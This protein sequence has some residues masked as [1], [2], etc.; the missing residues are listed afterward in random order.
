MKH[1]L[2]AMAVVALGGTA[3][4]R[5]GGSDVALSGDAQI[6]G[7]DGAV[8]ATTSPA[9]LDTVVASGDASLKAPLWTARLSRGTRGVLRTEFLQGQFFRLFELL[10]GSVKLD[11]AWALRA[12]T[13]VVRAQ[14]ASVE[15]SY[16]NGILVIKVGDG[17]TV[18]ITGTSA[19]ITLKNG[20]RLQISYDPATGTFTIVVDEDN[21]Q[22]IDVKIGKTTFQVSKGDDVTAKVSGDN[23]IVNAISGDV[24]L[25]G[26]DGNLVSVPQGGQTT[27][28]GGG[29]GAVTPGIQVPFTPGQ[30][31]NPKLLQLNPYQNPKTVMSN[32]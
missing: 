8:R 5:P 28:V 9:D 16:K 11:G 27:V 14:A 4:G 7:M 30:K 21:G 19:S 25:V 20:Q 3:F 29:K 23:L 12:G 10:E 17:D 22:P 24:S 32:S 15:A 13:L 18:L 6:L 26:P 31:D 2:F 1:M